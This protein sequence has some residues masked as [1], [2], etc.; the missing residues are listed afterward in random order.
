MTVFLEIGYSL[1]TRDVAFSNH[2]KSD[3]ENQKETSIRQVEKW[4]L[5][6]LEEYGW[7]EV[8]L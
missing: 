6:E 5:V 8:E 1:F 7:T 2:N 3:L 4:L